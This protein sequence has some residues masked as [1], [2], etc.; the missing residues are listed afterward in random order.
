MV[1][2]NHG[3]IFKYAAVAQDEALELVG[4]GYRKVEDRITKI[5]RTGKKTKKGKKERESRKNT[6][7]DRDG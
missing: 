1:S 5:T 4:S 3:E 6:R 7:S 2:N